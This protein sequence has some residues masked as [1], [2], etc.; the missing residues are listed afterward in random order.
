MRLATCI[1]T[2]NV[3]FFNAYNCWLQKCLAVEPPPP[4]PPLPT[5]ADVEEPWLAR[6]DAAAQAYG[7]FL[8]ELSF[9]QWE[10]PKPSVNG[11]FYGRIADGWCWRELATGATSNRPP[12]LVQEP[13]RVKWD[14][15]EEEFY[16]EN[17]DG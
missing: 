10:V 17:P 9:A 11:W 4:P 13:W 16:Y 12:P 15:F 1:R 5:H 2:A 8:R 3:L 6:W 14:S 7:F